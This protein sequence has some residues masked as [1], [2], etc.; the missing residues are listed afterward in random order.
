M[1]MPFKN[2]NKVSNHKFL[3]K[4]IKIKIMFLKMMHNKILIQNPNQVFTCK[5]SNLR[6]QIKGKKKKINFIPI[7]INKSNKK[8][9]FHLLSQ[10]KMLHKN[11]K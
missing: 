7:L 10:L 11:R 5:I 3:F 9:L 6:L 2:L 4:F 8:K 1:Q